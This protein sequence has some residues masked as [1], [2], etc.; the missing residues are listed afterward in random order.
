VTAQP[1]GRSRRGRDADV[2]LPA[3]ICLVGSELRSTNLERDIRDHSLNSPYVGARALDV[4]DRVANAVTDLKR[5]RAWSFTGPYGSGKSTLANLLDAFLGHDL[6]RRTEAEAAVEVTSPGLAAR[7]AHA[8][9][10]QAPEGFLGAVVTA[11][12]E[13]LASTVSRALRTA[14]DRKWPQKPPKPVA[15]AL[16][17]CVVSDVP[18]AE[19]L[20]QAVTALCGT[21]L[22]LLLVIDEFGKALEYIAAT[23]DSA[24]AES[25]VFLLQMLAEKGAG[26][27]GLP[28]FICT[29]QHLAF[30]DYAAN[31][32][33]IQ[34]KEWA[35]VQGRFEDVTFT[36]NLG[37][38]V[39]L[40]LR[41]LDH[42]G[43]EETGQA[44]IQHQARASAQAWTGHG[45]NAVVSVSV[46]MFAG[47]YPLHPLTAVAAPLLAAQIGQHDRSLTGFLTGDEPNTVRRTLDTASAA[48]PSRATTIR[49][50]QLYEYFFASGRNTILASANASRWL[51]VDNRLNQAHGLP[52]EDRETLRAIGILNLIDVDGVLRATP[53][54]IQFALNDPL[55]A[56]DPRLFDALQERLRRLVSGGFLVHRGYSDE[57]RV[58]EGSNFDIDAGVKARTD[59][60]APDDVAERL[61]EQIGKVLPREVVAGAHTERTGMV[62]FFRSAISYQAGKIDG[63]EAAREAADGLLVYHLGTPDTRPAVKTDLP[64]L[65]GT[66]QDSAAILREGITLIALQDLSVDKKLDRVARREVDERIAVISRGIR[67]TLNQAFSPGSTKATWQLWGKGTDVI[68]Q[69][70]A[71]MKA[72]SYAAL[73][74]QACDQIYAQ[75]PQIRNEMAG[76]HEL[77]SNGS[78]ARHELLARLL[79]DADQPILGF[80]SKKY[81]PERAM[82]HGVVEY[83]GLHR[84]ADETGNRRVGG[85]A[86]FRPDPNK[87]PGVIPAWNAL[88]MA[89]VGAENP[90]PVSEI[91]R[92]LMMPPYGVKAGVIPILVVTALILHAEDVALFEEGSYCT[93]LTLEIVERLLGDPDG[94]T[95]KAAPSGT[96]QRH[97]V[98]TAISDALGIKAPRLRTARN[99]ELLAV[100]R[101]ILD[102]VR[103][104]TP[105]ARNTRRLSPQA[106]GI[107]TVLSRATDPDELI[108]S[109]VPLALG[110]DPV[111]TDSREDGKAAVSYAERLTHAL[112]ELSNADASLRQEVATALGQEFRLPEGIGG[113]RRALTERLA[114]FD[115]APLEISLQ[116][117]VSRV[118]NTSL[119][120]EDW[121]DPIIIRLANKA[122]GDWTDQDA[123]DFPRQARQM[124]RSLER[125]SHLYDMR[126]SSSV[127][128]QKQT[129]QDGLK[130]T[131]GNPKQIQ[132]R[133]LTFTTPE[134]TEEHTL[135][136]LP[137]QARRAAET[138]A[139]KVIKQAEE[140]L[141]PDGAR[142]LLAMLAERLAA[143]EHSDSANAKE[144]P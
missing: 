69:T 143:D 137:H 3:G 121:L 89:L 115:G 118:T 107:R 24:S 127:P 65:V 132:T 111:T 34:T 140:E 100:T 109:A 114:G 119:P 35:K 53:A 125:V 81:P 110:L 117:F 54:M 77:T 68:A 32:S 78:R 86:V 39:H 80:D 47:L 102:R 76:R 41:R 50:P 135:V 51:E 79:S 138:L 13:P 123:K 72:R 55:D 33:A 73:V 142:I 52:E 27:A 44:L 45:L 40:M 134:G 108:F 29:L 113:L 57:Y 88:E 28:L 94:F 83:L 37:D 120:D 60:L 8:R 36:P 128:T 5:T 90:T 116:G 17:A 21:G 82:Y 136:H 7:F 56:K 2:Q 98:I 23:G 58:W 129:A 96:G 26:R 141:G 126:K 103:I 9:D 130:T 133:L 104:L 85:Y 46:E 105:Y 4:L 124:A 131:P 122:I 106:L 84:S 14:V 31:S 30:T 25:D 62:R 59:K 87:N 99:P 19:N 16:A 71:A 67:N 42:S 49:L 11:T 18:T 144:T 66:T 91:Y 61:I 48:Q 92:Q 139:D 15:D 93:Q 70:S 6:A 1:V 101:A 38:A 75:S 10:V 112:D 20:I 63:P 12:R 64:V 74:S 95:V 43:I 22:P 97:L